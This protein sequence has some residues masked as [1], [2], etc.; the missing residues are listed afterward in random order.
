MVIDPVCGI[1]LDPATAIATREHA[2]QTLY[3]HSQACVDQYDDDPHY[4]GHPDEHPHAE[5]SHQH[6]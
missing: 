5:A 2:G 1:E 3:F 6:E 4:Y